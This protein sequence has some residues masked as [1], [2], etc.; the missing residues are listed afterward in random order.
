MSAVRPIYCF[1]AP[2][3][4]EVLELV[5][6]AKAE[7]GLPYLVTLTPAQPGCP[8]RVLSF[9]V[10]PTFVCD[11]AIISD[12]T[13]YESILAALQ[14]VVSGENREAGFLK[15]DFLPRWIPGA[16]YVGEEAIAA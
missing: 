11:T 7:L 9:G 16:R 4:G 2:P 5:K 1:P 14:W 15:E 3:A 12:A 13:R 8:D 10:Y 6:R